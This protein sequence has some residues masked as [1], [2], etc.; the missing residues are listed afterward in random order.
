MVLT[1]DLLLIL[2]HALD[3]VTEIAIGD[4][5]IVLGVTVILHQRQ[6]V[7]VGDIQ[8]EPD[9]SHVTQTRGALGWNKTHEL[10]LLTGD[11]GDVHVVGGGRQILELLASE[12]I[13]GDQVDLGVTV[14]ASLGGGHL[15]DLARTAL[16]D[17]VTVLPQSRALH[18]EG[19]RGTGISRLEGDLVLVIMSAS[20]VLPDSSRGG[21]WC[22]RKE[23]RGQ[24]RGS[25]T[26]Q[27]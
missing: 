26:A 20:R 7:V 24:M 9:Q 10:V 21:A 12:D 13:E 15:D 18:G 6:E 16:D 8:L 27:G 5:D 14:L 23:G 4:L 22:T 1:D 11:V 3:L 17:D 25:K 19:A 2:K